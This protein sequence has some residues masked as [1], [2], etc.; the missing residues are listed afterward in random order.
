MCAECKDRQDEIDALI[1]QQDIA[2]AA[3]R[4]IES[5]CDTLTSDN[6]RL[7]QQNAELREAVRMYKE[8]GNDL[9]SI[10][11]DREG[12]KNGGKR[13]ALRVS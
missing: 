3:I 1:A 13:K 9:T 2:D 12:I 7:R 6:A 10:L 8:C 4:E 11:C 5:T